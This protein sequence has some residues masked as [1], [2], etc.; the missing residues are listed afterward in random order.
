MANYLALDASTEACSVALLWQG[1][2]Y[3]LF[4]VC[5]Q[6]HSTVLLPMVDKV[7][8]QAGCKLNQ[9]DGLV[10]GRGPGSFTG[11]RIGVGVVQG[12]AFSAQL[13][14]VGIST[15]Q[16]MAQ[17]A[18]IEHQQNEVI[19]AIDARMSEI[20][21]GFYRLNDDNIMTPVIN[22]AVI[23]PHKLAE[24]LIGETQQTYG[25]GTGWQA[26]AE[27]IDTLKLNEVDILYPTAYAMLAI[28]LPEFAQGN[29]VDAANAQPVYVRDTVSWKKLP[30]R[31]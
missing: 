6:S 9:L 27:D 17:Q 13:P 19:A 30:G 16:A 23:P 3:T 18:F 15:L 14:V 31:E 11:V 10:F 28:A 20:Y 1:Q 26:Y 2:E 12:L 4:E 21:T 22:E 8:K 24:L 5:P 7:L 29:T 25:V